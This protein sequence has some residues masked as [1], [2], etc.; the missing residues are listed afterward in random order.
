MKRFLMLV[1][2]VAAAACSG[3]GT[4]PV[5]AATLADSAEQIIFD[6]HA[7][8]TNSGVKRG[9]MFADTIYVFRDQTLFVLRK[10]R[11]IFNTET[12]APNGTLKGE[13]GTYDLRTQVL[14]GYGNVVVTSTDG[15]RLTSN[16]LKYAQAAN[17]ISSDSAF[18][19]YRGK[20]VQR[21]I[22]FVSDPNIT[23]FK[24]L[25][26]CSVAADVP[27]GNLTP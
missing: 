26:A 1:A 19:F 22:G 3:T 15:K 24:C 8:M 5:S 14:E 21:G 7:L 9:D 6:G 25:R 27:I 11:A 23:V 2:A 16:H 10:V 20:D 18:V 12:G 17:Q 4:P 13:R